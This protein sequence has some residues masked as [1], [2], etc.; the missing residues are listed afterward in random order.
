[1]HTWHDFRATLATALAAADKSHA[2]IQAAVCWASP[3]SVA[4]YGQQKPEAMADAADLATSIDASRH[5]HIATP[6]VCDDTVVDELEVCM[7]HL[8][9]EPDG[10]APTKQLQQ[11]GR[12]LHQRRSRQRRRRQRQRQRCGADTAPSEAPPKAKPAK[13][14]ATPAPTVRAPTPAPSTSTSTA[15]YDVG[16]PLGRVHIEH[17]HQLDGARVSI[18]N[19]IWGAG[20]GS[21][22]CTIVG[23]LPDVRLWGET[24]ALVVTADDDALH[25]A[26]TLP[27]IRPYLTA[28]QRRSLP[29]LP[30]KRQSHARRPSPA[31]PATPK[32]GAAQKETDSVPPS[33]APRRSPRLL[34]PVCDGQRGGAAA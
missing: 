24:G 1:M 5:A 6:H 32:M 26:L 4:L 10:H 8:S 15:T 16:A 14:K 20:G 34:P 23:Y 22:W 31:P 19:E 9:A 11:S 7:A 21:T 30:P 3:A 13:K 27:E 18:A 28:S 33:P 29:P 17:E 12:E 25:Y 2:F